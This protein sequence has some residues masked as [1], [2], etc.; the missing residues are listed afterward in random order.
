MCALGTAFGCA[1]V[2]K[3][4]SNDIGLPKPLPM[5]PMRGWE[6]S[7]ALGPST[8]L[9]LSSRVSQCKDKYTG[10]YRWP[11]R[12]VRQGAEN[13]KRASS[14]A[15]NIQL[16]SS[17]TPAILFCGSFHQLLHHVMM[18]WCLLSNITNPR[19]RII[20]VRSPRTR[21]SGLQR[22]R[23]SVWL[24]GPCVEA[25]TPARPPGV[26]WLL[27]FVHLRDCARVS[28]SD[29]ARHRCWRAR[30]HPPRAHGGIGDSF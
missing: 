21:I 14:Q 1:S 9:L 20:M 23:R 24:C 19:T 8:S 5:R 6:E 29:C 4:L 30:V 28:G 26:C 10:Y 3:Q 13:L 15:R 16:R 17:T 27:V 22:P 7:I 2:L 12:L 11:V 18:I 25:C